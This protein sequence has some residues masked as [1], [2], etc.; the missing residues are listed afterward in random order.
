VRMAL[1]AAGRRHS[2]A[3]Q[4]GMFTAALGR[5]DPQRNPV[6]AAR[7]EISC[8]SILRKRRG[9]GLILLTRHRFILVDQRSG[10]CGYTRT[11]FARA[12]AADC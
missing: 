6:N 5:F 1:P 11:S 3:R 12:P 10:D 9:D 2:A 4:L 7:E 8:P